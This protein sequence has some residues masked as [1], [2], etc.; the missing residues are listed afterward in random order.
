MVPGGPKYI[1]REL[2][3]FS[4]DFQKNFDFSAKIENFWPMHANVVPAKNEILGM[5][6]IA[7]NGLA[8]KKCDFSKFEISIPQSNQG[9][10]NIKPM[11]VRP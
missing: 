11:L 3:G 4:F 10:R 8:A 7:Q 6:K 1:S 9:K 5:P 2:R